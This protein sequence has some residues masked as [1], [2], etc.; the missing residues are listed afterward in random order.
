MELT[1]GGRLR[2]QRERQQ[3]SLEAIA[4]DTKIKVSLLEGLERDDL[5]HWPQRIYRRAYV[6]SY[7]RAVGLDPETVVREFIELYPD[8]VE[9]SPDDPIVV[10]DGGGAAPPASGTIFRRLVTSAIGAVPAFLQRSDRSDAAAPAARTAQPAERVDT[11]AAAAGATPADGGSDRYQRAHFPEPAE[12][13]ADLELALDRLYPGDDD[14]VPFAE[15]GPQAA[16]VTAGDRW[17]DSDAPGAIAARVAREDR[18]AMAL[19]PAPAPIGVSRPAAAASDFPLAAL[20]ELC[21]RLGQV[22]ERRELLPLLDDAGRLLDA[23]GLIVWLWDRRGNVLRASI[24]QGYADAVLAQWPG[25]PLDAENGIAAAFR[26]ASPCVVDGGGALTGAVVV[27]LLG[28]HECAGVLA[29]ELRHGGERRDSVQAAATIL[30]AQLAML[31]GPAPI[32]EA[33]HS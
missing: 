32:A 33:V 10:P 16:T 24:A 8:P 28:P 30:A 6:R 21:T 31:L 17:R 12:S 20:A 29:L 9:P 26:S 7:A 15:D 23:V 25:V 19:D 14:A 3:I 2:Q 11:A 4:A 18:D 22:S 27:P 13:V 1:F 5:S